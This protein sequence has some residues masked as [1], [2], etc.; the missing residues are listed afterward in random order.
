MA[1]TQ[2]TSLADTI[3][4]C[5]TGPGPG[6]LAVVRLS[7][8][9]ALA[10]C[11][12]MMTRNHMPESHK[13]VWTRFHDAEGAVIDHGMA[14][15]M[16]APRSYTGEDVVEMHVH[17]SRA[18]VDAIIHRALQLGARLAGPGEFTM[19]AFLRGRMDLAQAEA[20]G[21][22][23]AA[24]DASERRA[25]T[26]QLEGSLSRRIQH[27]IDVLEGVLAEWRAALDFPEYPTGEGMRAEHLAALA[28]VGKTIEDLLRHSEA[29]LQGK[30]HVVLCG[31]PNVGKSSLLNAWTGEERVLVHDV[32]GTTR[33]PVEIELRD[34]LLRWS[35]WDTAGIRESSDLLE[36]RGMQ[37][38]LE[39]A[40]QAERCVWLVAALPEIH[41][42][43]ADLNVTWI[44]GSKADCTSLAVREAIEAE[45]LARGYLFWGWISTATGE[46]VERLRVSVMQEPGLDTTARGLGAESGKQVNDA[47]RHDGRLG[48]NDILLIRQRH[49]DALVR[50]NQHRFAVQSQIEEGWPLDI[51]ARELEL[52]V[53]ALG[54]ITG[55]DV[56][57]DVIDRIFQTFCI[58]K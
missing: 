3:V 25:A 17:G 20:V 8:P 46:G 41:W 40:R 9:Q 32:P 44:V 30:R 27:S 33:D 21:D 23:I 54:E 22:L 35:V 14:V 10:I 2:H 58:G 34:G 38:A 37:M 52:M 47:P 57:A 13:L 4:A 42:P 18:V 31:A 48:A 11:K 43:A 12:G 49:S 36:Q 28:D 55:R 7:G 24:N 1:L 51:V 29:V 53:K 39:R 5:A 15:A 26:C 16:Q 19:R 6:P 45:A 50:A 56:D